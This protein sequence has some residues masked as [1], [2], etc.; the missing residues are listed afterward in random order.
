MLSKYCAPQ[1][2]AALS[3]RALGSCAMTLGS[4]SADK[5]LKRLS[6]GLQALLLSVIGLG[7]TG[8]LWAATLVHSPTWREFLDAIATG[9]LVSA[10]FGIAQAL[11]TSRVSSELLRASV[12]DEVAR[13][14]AQASNAYYPINEFSASSTPDPQ[15]NAQLMSDLQESSTFWFRGLSGR[16]A[17]ARLSFNQNVSLQAHLILPDP[18]VPGTFEG[19]VDYVARHQI[20]PGQD[21]EQIRE[22]VRHDIRLGMCGLF[23]AAHKCAILELV[24]TPMPLLDRYEIFRDAIWVTLFS[25]PGQGTLF[26]RTLRFSASSVMYLMQ[27]AD[28]L[29]VRGHPS[30]RL[31]QFPRIVTEANIFEMFEE[32]TGEGITKG[33]YVAL[34]EEFRKFADS[35][36]RTSGIR[37]GGH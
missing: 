10:A 33:E 9:L 18:K 25:D 3:K 19:R 24:L 8:I 23:E 28:C 16:Y 4:S 26:P 14:L 17:A 34:V 32:I 11:I 13:S 36:A 29:Q 1:H 21:L 7:A 20:Y 6:R 37:R 30:A 31:V 35:F 12:V 2:V 27:Q 5:L 22:R 15:F